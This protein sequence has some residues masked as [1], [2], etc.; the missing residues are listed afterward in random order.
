MLLYKPV[1]YYGRI[2]NLTTPRAVTVLLKCTVP[3]G[4]CFMSLYSFNNFTEFCVKAFTEY[5][6]IERKIYNTHYQYFIAGHSLRN[7]VLM[8]CMPSRTS[9][10]ID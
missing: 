8:Y 10:Y 3:T 2:L 9:S 4:Q 6:N 5:W 7:K 1:S